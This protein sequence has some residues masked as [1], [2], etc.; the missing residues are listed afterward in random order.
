VP[1]TRQWLTPKSDSLEAFA[2]FVAAMLAIAAV[3][4]LAVTGKATTKSVTPLVAIVAVV[5]R[6]WL[7]SSPDAS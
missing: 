1:K 2:F 4:Y 5:A 7:S 3:I 6:R